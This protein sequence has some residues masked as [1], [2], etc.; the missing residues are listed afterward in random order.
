MN[1]ETFIKAF[2]KAINGGSAGFIPMSGQV[3]SM[4]WLRTILII[5]IEMEE[6]LNQQI[7]YYIMKVVL[8]DF[9]EDC[10]LRFYK[11]HYQDLVIQQ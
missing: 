10:L 2:N 9:I 6:H 4:M 5:N 3:V 11:L 8:L 7:N 1:K